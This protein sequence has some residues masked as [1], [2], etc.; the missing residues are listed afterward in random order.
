TNN[1]RLFQALNPALYVK[2]GIN[3]YIVHGRQNA[4]NPEQ[5]GTKVAAHHP[6]TVAAGASRTVQLRLSDK[7]PDAMA[8]GNGGPFGKGFD[9]LLA[10]RRQEADAFYAT[11]IPASLGSDQ[12]NVMR[13]ALAGMMWTK[14]AYYYD[15]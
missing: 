3:D 4:V 10:A 11:V 15:V 13:Q 1:E 8:E 7:A 2:D 12:A 6:L 9:M 14:Q 5:R